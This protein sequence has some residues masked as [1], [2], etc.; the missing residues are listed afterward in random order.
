[1]TDDGRHLVPVS[2]DGLREE[3]REDVRVPVGRGIAGRIATSRVGLIVPDVTQSEVFSPFIRDRVTSLIGAPMRAGDRLI[4]VIHVGS[5]TPRR[6]TEDDLALLRL[7]ADQVAVVIERARVFDAERA[8][9][10]AAESA[11]RMKDEFLAMLSHELRSP[12]NAIV[13]FSHMLMKKPDPDV[14][15]A[16]EVIDRNAR[17]VTRLVDDL[18]DVSRIVAGRMAIEY[19]PVAIAPLV[20]RLL[21]TLEPAALEKGLRLDRK[22]EPSAGVVSGDYERLHQAIGNLVMN[23]IKF[24]PAGGSV[25]IRVQGTESE[26]RITVTDT[27]QGIAPEFLPHVFERFRQEALSSRRSIASRSLA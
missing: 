19:R 27:G 20:D 1:V 21:D 15:R 26:V 2:S 12:L 24:T 8:A 13:G 9:R 7:V 18:L 17:L 11:S 16:V 14:R 25:E 4:G 5:S 6:F 3:V 23:A 22:V 10:Q